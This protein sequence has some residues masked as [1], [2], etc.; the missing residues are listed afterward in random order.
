MTRY[1]LHAAFQLQL[2]IASVWIQPRAIE[3]P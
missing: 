2:L 3:I 1:S